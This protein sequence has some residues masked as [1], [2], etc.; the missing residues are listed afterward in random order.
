MAGVWPGLSLKARPHF[1]AGLVRWMAS[2]GLHHAASNA[3]DLDRAIAASALA[4]STAIAL[5]AGLVVAAI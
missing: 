5:V 4:W 1:P 3:Y 2:H